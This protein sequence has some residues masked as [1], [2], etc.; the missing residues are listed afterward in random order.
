MWVKQYND[1][2]KIKLFK[3]KCPTK[4]PNWLDSLFILPS[5]L[6]HTR[7]PKSLS[8]IINLVPQ[9]RRSVRECLIPPT[10]P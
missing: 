5:Q 10:L 1:K 9:L 8:S 7:Q 3:R 2:H 4:L 6:D